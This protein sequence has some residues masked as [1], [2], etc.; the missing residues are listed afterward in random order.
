MAEIMGDRHLG[1]HVIDHKRILPKPRL[2]AEM[3]FNKIHFSEG[4]SVLCA[5]VIIS[6]ADPSGM[7]LRVSAE[8]PARIAASA[9]GSNRFET[10]WIS[11]LIPGSV[12]EKPPPT[13]A[14]AY[15]EKILRR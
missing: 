6:F 3:F 8:S 10:G 12:S 9:L 1:A 7:V 4:P 11:E 5:N 2:D 15:T 14:T 13:P